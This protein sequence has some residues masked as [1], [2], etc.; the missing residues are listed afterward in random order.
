MVPIICA[1]I[2]KYKKIL[3]FILKLSQNTLLWTNKL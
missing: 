3:D 2:K 1:W